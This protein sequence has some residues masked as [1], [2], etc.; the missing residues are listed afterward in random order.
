MFYGII[1]DES[2]VYRRINP[3]AKTTF[4]PPTRV[5]PRGINQRTIPKTAP[6]VRCTTSPTTNLTHADDVYVDRLSKYQP[7]C[8]PVYKVNH[9]LKI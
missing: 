2:Y 8:Q 1:N 5:E 6:P 9:I 4:Q 7:H 3:K